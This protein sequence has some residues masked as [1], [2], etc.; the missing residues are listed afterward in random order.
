MTTAT[1]TRF[2][3]VPETND[4]FLALFPHRFD[5]IWAE[6]PAP[7]TSPEWRTE[8][9]HP[10]SDRLIQQA[11]Y[12]YGVRFG[13]QTSYGLLDIDAD[14]AYHPHHDPFA[15]SRIVAA[16][17]PLG[18]VTPV[19]CTSSDSGGLH[20]Y[21]P[22]LTS[23]SSWRLAIGMAA[24]LE[25]A[26]FQL[27]PGQLE[28]FPNPKPYSV[29]GSLSL[30]HAHRLPLQVGSYL[31]NAD[32]QPI[33]SDRQTFV[34]QWNFA[35]QH[36]ELNATC[37][38]RILKVAKRR[39]FQ[40]TGKADKFINDLNAEVE[41]GWTG[42]GQTNRLLGRIT[43]REYIFRHVLSGCKPLEGQ[44]LVN[45]VVEIARSLPGYFEWCRHQHEIE[46][47]V[48]EWV[49]CIETSHYFHYGDPSGKFKAKLS[50]SEPESDLKP[51]LEQLP[52]WNQQQSA[53]ARE[54]IRCAIA[55]LLEKG[56][57]P[58]KPTA[59]FH[60]LT[61]HGIGG[62]SLYRHR[63][64]WH[65]H[66]LTDDDGADA[67]SLGNQPVET[68]PHPP[69]LLEDDA[70]DCNEGAS[71]AS[72]LP[73]LFLSCGGNVFPDGGSNDFGQDHAGELGRN[74]LQ[75]PAAQS[76]ST[77]SDDRPIL[78]PLMEIE[79][80][81]AI[82]VAGF[83]LE[84]WSVAGTGHRT[85]YVQRTD[86]GRLNS[87]L[88]REAIAQEKQIA[89]NPSSSQVSSQ[90]SSQSSSSS[91]DALFHNLASDLSTL[92]RSHPPRD[93]SDVLG[94]I[95]IHRQRIG[96]SG[97]WWRD[98]LQRLFGKSSQAQLDDTELVRWL[99]WLE[100]I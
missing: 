12:L 7:K 60:A 72:C 66:C 10:L 54:R 90:V 64:L 98:R 95:A 92:E 32:F 22:F 25:N 50:A 59:R 3:S 23:Q 49:R 80:S 33:W 81:D 67:A 88:S 41:K 100:S 93:L 75:P 43:M 69:V 6:Y 70:V 9:R 82:R 51:A 5:Y 20:L 36:N 13:A 87:P 52:T 31:L 29:D 19:A 4:P 53:S 89:S 39:H 26:G 78:T 97:E 2:Q 96:G 17:E 57:L 91:G 77:Q 45:A 44:A 76:S 16:L 61:R 8:R 94:W 79:R 30:F 15:V 40:I 27:V 73:S 83:A 56:A 99:E 24:L 21:F 34:Q 85:G 58:A 71:T 11:T 42:S 14:S 86:C 18:L 37:L 35:Q 1:R 47:R 38:T 62:S 68:P 63:D 84:R 65:P 46:H 74:D 28:I 48:S 55:D